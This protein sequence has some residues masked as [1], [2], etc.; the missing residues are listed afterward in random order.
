VLLSSG[1]L[2]TQRTVPLLTD[3]VTTIEDKSKYFI[4]ATESLF[5]SKALEDATNTDYKVYV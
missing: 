4:Q 2:K 3:E 5:K 1:I